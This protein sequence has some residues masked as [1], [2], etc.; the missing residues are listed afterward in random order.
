MQLCL[1]EKVIFECFPVI[2]L[3]CYWLFC[4]Y[5]LNL[6]L[7]SFLCTCIFQVWK[8]NMYDNLLCCSSTFTIWLK[9]T[10]LCMR[11]KYSFVYMVVSDFVLHKPLPIE[12]DKYCVRFFW[13]T[14]STCYHLGF[15]VSRNHS[16]EVFKNSSP[17]LWYEFLA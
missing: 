9:L 12:N 7:L 4:F 8:W 10:L 5:W 14:W 6:S 3:H 15:K 1:F 11:R 2:V 16:Q 17:V 13:K